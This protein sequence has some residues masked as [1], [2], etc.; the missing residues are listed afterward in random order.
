[1]GN[2]CRATDR[3]RCWVHR[4]GV[5]VVQLIRALIVFYCPVPLDSAEGMRPASKVTRFGHLRL[6][7][8]TMP[9]S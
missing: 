9:R 6:D 7:G 8:H 3:V 1:M 4:V 5:V 2:D